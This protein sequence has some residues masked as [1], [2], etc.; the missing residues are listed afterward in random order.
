MD[1][2]YFRKSTTIVILGI[3][4]VLSFFLVKSLLLSIVGGILLAFVFSPI[5][6]FLCKVTKSKT[7][8]ASI[9]CFVFLFSILLSLWFLAPKMIDE[10]IKLYKTVQQMDIVTPLKTIF[11]NLF[12]SPEFSQEVGS[13]L[14]SFIIKAINSLV[15]SLT[16]MLLEL[17]TILMQIFVVFFTLFYTLRD[18]EKLTDYIKSFLP[19]S[20]EVV[21]KLFESTKDITFS[22]LYGQLICGIIQGIILGIGLIIFGVP[23]ALLLT[24]AAI[25]LGVLPIIGPVVIGIPVAISFLLGGNLPSAIGIS[26]FTLISTLSDHFFRPLLVS[27]RTKLNPALVLIGMIGGLLFIGILGLV[28]GPLILAYLAIVLEI[29]RNKSLPGVLIQETKR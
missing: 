21:N 28:L 6:N 5:Y 3:L 19:F 18:K 16:D 17:P 1:Q 12:T 22:V 11:P 27:K 8:S 29:Y 20:K 14:H 15:T 9:V 24:L 25:I 23:N 2:A 13:V 4:L 10:S 7:L 26:I